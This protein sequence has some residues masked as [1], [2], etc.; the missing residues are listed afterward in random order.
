MIVN[1]SPTTN[2]F[3]AEIL[4]ARLRVNYPERAAGSLKAFA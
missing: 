2:P 4:R 3:S 1:A